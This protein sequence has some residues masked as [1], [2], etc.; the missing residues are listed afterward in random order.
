ME[1]S[2][3]S[4]GGTLSEATAVT[5]LVVVEALRMSNSSCEAFEEPPYISGVRK[6]E[7]DV[8]GSR[9]LEATSSMKAVPIKTCFVDVILRR[10]GSRCTH[11]RDPGSRWVGAGDDNVDGA[12]CSLKS[13]SPLRCL[14]KTRGGNRL[15][16]Q[17]DRINP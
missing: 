5:E 13:F 2:I 12:R 4:C 7:K 9:A 15:T 17:V 8:I 11:R 1:R 10:I 6:K 14:L 3:Q 16:R